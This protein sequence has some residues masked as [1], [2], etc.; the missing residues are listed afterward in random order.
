MRLLVAVAMCASLAFAQTGKP[1]RPSM[2][3]PKGWKAPR[4]P[5]GV[6]DLQG[7]WTNVTI[8][9]LQRPANLATKAVFTEA[10]AEAFEK[11]TVAR[12]NADVRTTGASDVANAY[13]DFWYNRGDQ[14]VPTL[15]T[16]LIVDPPDGRIPALT[17]YGRKLAAERAEIRR[18]R[19]PADGPESRS[20]AERCIVWPTGGPPMLSS[21]Y[22]N[23]YQIVQG[24]GYV[25]I[26]VEMIHD[27]RMIPTDGRPHVSE[28]I[29]LWMGDPVGHWEG[30][31][32]I[33]E[34]TNFTND[35]PFQGSSKDMKLIEK[36]TRVN[37]DVLMYEFTVNDPVF[38][39][40]WTAQLPMTPIEGPLYEY[41]CNEGNRAM[42]GML[43]GAREDEKAKR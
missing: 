20:L 42:E 6:P 17:D 9:P 3:T 29:R 39:K 32:L 26:Y 4:I 23:N 2:A 31:T 1:R 28:N 21:F 38:T 18:Q 16:S 5:D 8:T 34:T 27:V 15:R 41:A 36:F 33:V 25:A 35:S 13:N 22:N 30:D 7:M 11:E 19:G 37:N 43:A 10:E 40:P 24:P 12:N 14:V